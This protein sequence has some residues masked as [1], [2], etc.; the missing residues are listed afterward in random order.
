L[1]RVVLPVVL[2]AIGACNSPLTFT[3]AVHGTG[4]SGA[5]PLADGGGDIAISGTGGNNGSG[6]DG[7]GGNGTGGTG[8]ID[9]P[10]DTPRVDVPVDIG[11]DLRDTGV[12]LPRDTGV[13]VGPVVCT[14]ASQCNKV[15]GLTCL[16]SAG[17][18]V[19]CVANSDCAG[20]ALA[21]ICDTATSHR[22]VECLSAS[23]CPLAPQPGEDSPKPSQCTLS[24]RCLN[25][26]DDSQGNL[27]PARSPRPFI[28]CAGSGLDV[29]V[30]CMVAGDCGTGGTCLDHVCVTCLTDGDCVSTAA[31]P[32]CDGIAGRCVQ[33]RD[34]VDCTPA[35]YPGRPLCNPAT[36]TCVAVPP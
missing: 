18:C 22:C 15:P 30:Y 6:G 29:C 3:N 11:P 27:C 34:S 36:L 24:H 21:T 9:A 7:T 20:N 12:D 35:K 2:L 4:G 28:Q 1:L 14:T 31:T 10:V 23:Q 32:I 16:V 13:D 26:C 5:P 19:E 33:C 8:P 25:G 17:R